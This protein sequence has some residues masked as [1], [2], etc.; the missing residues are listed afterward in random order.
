MAVL[1][2]QSTLCAATCLPPRGPAVLVLCL[3]QAGMAVLFCCRVCRDVGVG[4]G[5]V[6]AALQSV[7]HFFETYV[8]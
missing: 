8:T 7:E 6:A 1:A 3:E 2:H 4:V 5:G